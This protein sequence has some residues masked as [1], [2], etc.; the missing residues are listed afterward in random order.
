MEN[1]NNPQRRILVTKGIP[2]AA[3]VVG[4]GAIEVVN[5]ISEHITDEKLV[6][7]NWSEH[8]VL[9]G[10]LRL[11]F[12]PNAKQNALVHDVTFTIKPE[13]AP[14]LQI[15]PTN[16]HQYPLDRGGWGILKIVTPDQQTGECFAE[17]PVAQLGIPENGMYEVGSDVYGWD[18]KTGQQT[19]QSISYSPDGIAKVSS[20][21]VSPS[22]P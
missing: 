3:F 2:A 6:G 11:G 14:L 5:L 20:Q 19:T 17:I 9:D 18:L 10:M 4:G 15:D 1:L 22:S 21:N 16:P 8:L 12:I 13:T 7:G